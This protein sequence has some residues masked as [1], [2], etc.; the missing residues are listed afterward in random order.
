ME[1][2]ELHI[3]DVIDIYDKIYDNTPKKNYYVY[4]V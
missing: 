2:S 4:V 3:A 1:I